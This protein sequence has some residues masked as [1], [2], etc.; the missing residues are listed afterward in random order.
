MDI[1]ELYVILSFECD[2]VL[3]TIS[4]NIVWFLVSLHCSFGSYWYIDSRQSRIQTIILALIFCC[5]MLFTCM[6]R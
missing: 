2:I 1:K 6:C 3:F 4:C 5:C